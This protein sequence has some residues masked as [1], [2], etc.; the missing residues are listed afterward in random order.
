[1]KYHDVW[2]PLN[3]IRL[4]VTDRCH[5]NCWWCHNE[6]TGARNPNLIGDILWDDSTRTAIEKIANFLNL[7]EVHLTGGEPTLHPQLTSLIKGIR[8]LGLN[9]KATSIGCDKNR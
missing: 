5:W 2:E 9:V 1:M 3:S 6:G 8:A 4:K 7:T